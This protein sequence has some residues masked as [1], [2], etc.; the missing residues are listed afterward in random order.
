MKLSEDQWDDIAINLKIGMLTFMHKKTGEVLSHPASEDMGIVDDTG[1]LY[2][3]QIQKIKENRKDY[4]RF[5]RMGSRE[6][7]EVM[8]NFAESIENPIYKGRFL[9]RLQ[10]PKPFAN[11]KQLVH[12]SPYRQDWFDF[13]DKAYREHFKK[14]FEHKM[15]YGE[16]D[17]DEGLW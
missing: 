9:E 8:E 11:F 15:K 2:A 12:N 17:D 4:V 14:E 16:E 3:D 10:L 7:F 6:A 13:R 5:E 1:E